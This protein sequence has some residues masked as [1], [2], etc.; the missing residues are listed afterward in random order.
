MEKRDR[1]EDG[2][3][4][5]EIIATLETIEKALKTGNDPSAVQTAIRTARKFLEGVKAVGANGRSPLQRLDDELSVWESKFP[6]IWREPA[7][8]QGMTKHMKHWITEL[9]KFGER[10]S[11]L[12]IKKS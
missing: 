6:V 9:K 4:M 12:G 2:Y 8:R 11:E 3:L 10:S 5:N 1:A 7:G